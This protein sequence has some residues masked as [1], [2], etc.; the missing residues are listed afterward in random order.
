[1]PDPNPKIRTPDPR[2]IY[3]T[4]V[5]PFP[6]FLVLYGARRRPRGNVTFVTFYLLS[7]YYTTKRLHVHA[8]KPLTGFP[9]G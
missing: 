9:Q 8:I 2:V 6:V 1:M 5:L 4:G 7:L 3:G